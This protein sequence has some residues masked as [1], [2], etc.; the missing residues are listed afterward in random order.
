MKTNSNICGF[1]SISKTPSK[2]VVD[3]DINSWMQT[4][5]KN[6]RTSL[7]PKLLKPIVITNTLASL[8]QQKQKLLCE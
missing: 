8:R 6:K 5:L 1:S 7:P 4:H 2:I 3:C